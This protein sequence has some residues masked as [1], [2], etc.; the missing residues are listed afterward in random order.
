MKVPLLSDTGQPSIIDINEVLIIKTT[1]NGPEFHTKE[2][3]YYF[4]STA[5]ELMELFAD[6]GFDKLDR[7]NLVN[8]N[9]AQAY[10]EKQRKVYFENPW[11]KHS[12]YASVSE[13]N[14]KKVQHLIRESEDTKVAY[15]GLSS[16]FRIGKSST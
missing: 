5:K 12:Q 13:A 16:R 1:S 10:D 3:V 7:C 11:D 6:Y 9:L 15:K 4:P 8:M 2:G 14:Q